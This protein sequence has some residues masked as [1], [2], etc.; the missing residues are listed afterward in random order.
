MKLIKIFS[1]IIMLTI[2]SGCS[3]MLK[4][5]HELFRIEDAYYQSWMVRDLE[6]GTDVFVELK[7]L[8]ADIEF[9][10]LVFRGVEVDVTASSEGNKTVIKGTVNTGP[11]LI[12]NYDYKTGGPGDIIRYFYKGRVYDYPLKNVRRENT[13]FIK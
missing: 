5:E 12:E 11:S 8:D 6:K 4:S 2:I 9:T 3:A 13:E 10:S 7:K 1:V